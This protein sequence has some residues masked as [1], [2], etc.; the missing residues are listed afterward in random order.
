MVAN[1]LTLQ[2]TYIYIYAV[3]LKTGPMFAFSSVKNWSKFFFVFLFFLFLKI[4]FSL[5][6]EEFSKKEKNKRPISSVKNWSNFVAQHTWTNFNASLDQFLTLVFFVF[7]LFFWGG[8]WNPYFYSVFSKHAK[9]KET[10]KR[11]KDTICEHTCATALV[12]MSFFCAFFIFVFF[13][14]AISNF[15]RDVFDR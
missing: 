11:K 3:E 8:G 2:H 9:I 1:L 12:K 5:Q 14:F 6:K 15:F 10:Q 4:S 7:F 13:F